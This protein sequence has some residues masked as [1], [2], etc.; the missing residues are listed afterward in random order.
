MRGV[1]VDNFGQLVSE[2][3]D[4]L[5]F[6]NDCLSRCSFEEVLFGTNE[7]DLV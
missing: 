1:H 2:L 3:G 4:K 7:D 6:A 5:K